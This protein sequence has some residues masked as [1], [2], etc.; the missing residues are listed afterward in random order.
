MNTKAMLPPYSRALRDRMRGG[1]RP[2]GGTLHIACGSRAIDLVHV[3]QREPQPSLRAWFAHFDDSDPG[4]LDWSL[5]RGFDVIAFGAG[6]L[7]RTR[8]D[9]IAR[10]S[11]LGGAARVLVIHGVDTSTP[12]IVRYRPRSAG[13][14]AA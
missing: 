3:W 2:P 14:V 11:F 5:V 9:D 4:V 7:T 10:A 13:R 1:W 6:E 12:R 8:A